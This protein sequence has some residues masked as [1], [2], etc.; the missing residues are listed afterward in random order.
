MSATGTTYEEMEE[1][2]ELEAMLN[3]GA[4]FTSKKVSELTLNER[5]AYNNEVYNQQVAKVKAARAM[6][7]N[8]RKSVVVTTNSQPTVIPATTKS[9]W[10]KLTVK[11]QNW[12]TRFIMKRG[13]VGLNTKELARYINVCFKVER[14]EYSCER[15]TEITSALIT[16][17]FGLANDDW[18]LNQ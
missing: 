4:R 7:A 3:C 13:V 10:D 12:L 14:G 16:R 1:E 9:T 11:Q 17:D 18:E 8:A 2:A 6:E 5:I 15:F